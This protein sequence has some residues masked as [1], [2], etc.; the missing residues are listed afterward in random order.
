MSQ[1]PL[2]ALRAFEAVARL[3]SFNAA[4]KALFVTQSAVSHQVRHLE[5]WLDRPLFDRS[6]ARP[7]LLPRGEALA[8]DL[9]LALNGIEVACAR[10]KAPDARPALVIA[11][12]PSVAL[13]WLIPRL[14][15]FRDRHP[16]IPV[17]IVYAIHGQTI[18]FREVD[19]AFTYAAT[20]PDLI[21]SRSEL[22]LPG[23]SVPV[24]NPAV[25]AKLHEEE[26][27]LPEAILQAGL[28]HDTDMSGWA[29]WLARAGLRLDRPLTG[30]TFEDF[31]LLRAAAL[32]GQGVALC[33]AAMISDDLDSD[34][35]VQLSSRSALESYGYYLHVAET[36]DAARRA[37]GETFREWALEARGFE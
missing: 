32:S 14:N 2:N 18:D 33:P 37:F 10:A 19:L 1:P 29:G 23:V 36:G 15:S 26:A 3:G 30:P 34:R 17:R 24:C 27:R 13:C 8:R 35:L 9:G 6:G 20:P 21:G 28:L 5:R 12:I 4:A 16:E 7:R 31:N 11:A 25:A 22:F